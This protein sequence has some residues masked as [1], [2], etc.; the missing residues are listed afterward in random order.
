MLARCDFFTQTDDVVRSNTHPRVVLSI[1]LCLVFGSSVE[2]QPPVNRLGFEPA[3]ASQVRVHMVQNGAPADSRPEPL[4]QLHQT[5]EKD[6]SVTRTPAPEMQ[7]ATP[8]ENIPT[9]Q[10]GTTLDELTEIAL[11]NNPTLVQAVADVQAARGNWVQVGLYP[12]PSMAY[13]GNQIG[14]QSRAGQQGGYIEQE[15]VRGRKLPLN[16]EVAAREI[17]I[18]E[19]RLVAQRMRVVNDVKIQFYNTLVAQRMLH[20]SQDLVGIG[21]RGYKAAN[22]MLEAK[23]TGRIDVLQARIEVNNA[24]IG[25]TNAQNRADAAWRRLA[26]LVGMPGM[27]PSVV[28]GDLLADMPAFT[29]EGAIGRML[30]ESPELAATRIG[31]DRAVRALRRARAEPTPNVTVQAGPQYDF[32]TGDTVTNVNASLPIPIFNYN[33][34][35]IRKAEAE[36]RS[37]RAEVARKELELT[38]R[39]AANFERYANA[40]NQVIKYQKE[41]LPDATEALKMVTNA[42]RAGESSFLV[43]LTAQR[44]YFYTNMAYYTAVQ[45]LWETSVT[46]DGLLLTDSLQSG[47]NDIG[48]PTVGV[49]NLTP[50]NAFF[51]R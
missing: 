36:V 20:I 4:P 1:F 15:F 37:A 3:P 32:G 35:N 25:V 7:L 12:N 42:Y 13:L 39:L 34:G 29:W 26:S 46:I 22:D 24:R 49:P 41:I 40:Q 23:E 48:G 2:A 28:T 16:R 38:T 8:Q 6:P 30:T 18:A 50:N 27:E 45:D 51:G 9:P 14:D 11:A 5:E 10:V 47:G 21:E 44:T 31:V 19:Q 43:L 33:Q 17:A